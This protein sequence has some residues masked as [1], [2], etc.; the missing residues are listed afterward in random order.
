MRKEIYEASEQLPTLAR[1]SKPAGTI[2][3]GESTEW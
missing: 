1:S 3:G 2:T